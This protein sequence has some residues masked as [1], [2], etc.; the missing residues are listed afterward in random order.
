M[1][2]RSNLFTR[3][4]TFLGVCQGLGDDLGFNPDLLRLAL[5]A[6]LFWNPLAM[7]VTYA[8]LGALVLAVRLLF[9]ARRAVVSQ[10]ARPVTEPAIGNDA[11]PE[12]AALA[13]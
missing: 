7:A 5:A 2:D 1:T 4:D 6:M 10:P 3:D 11:A 9:P 13:A 12:P 8:A